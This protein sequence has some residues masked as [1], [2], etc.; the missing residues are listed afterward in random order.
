[1]HTICQSFDWSQ[2][3][4]GASAYW[5]QS[6]RTTVQLIMAS[7][8]PTVVLWGE[9]LIQIYND[10]Y[11]E[12][13]GHR[14]PSGFGQP[15]EQSWPE[16]WD[17]NQSVYKRVW[18]GE[19]LYF[20]DA[21][22][23]IYHLDDSQEA[24]FTLAYS[25]VF[26]DSGHVGGVQLTVMRELTGRV[27]SRIDLVG[28][29]DAL[30]QA[31]KHLR[32]ATEAASMATWEWDLIHNKVYWNEQHF[33]ILGL[34]PRRNPVAP[35]LFF[36]H[37][38]PEDR[39]RVS[40]E[41]QQALTSD[42]L[43]NTEFRVMLE[44]GTVKWMSGYGR[45]ME[46]ADGQPTVMNG[47]MYD[48]TTRREAEDAL[49]ESEE[50]FRAFVTSTSDAVY[51][52][53]ADWQQMHQ[54]VGK[55]FLLDTATENTSWLQSYIPP[56]DQ[57]FVQDAIS[58]AIA[59]KTTF[60]LEHRVILADGELGWTFS[61]AIPKFDNKGDI[62]GWF[63][64][65]SDMTEYK[66]AQEA[67]IESELQYRLLF[68]S[69]D[70]G[71]CTIQLIFDEQ[72]KAVD[73][74]VLQ[75]NPA[76]IRQTGLTDAIGKTMRT[77]APA[78][79]E[80]WFETYGRIAKTGE[81]ARFEHE[82]AALGYFYDV[83]AFRIGPPEQHCVAVL[84]K[85]ISGRKNVEEA[86]RTSE[87]RL[88]A[89]FESLPVGVGE[90]DLQGRIVIANKAMERFMPNGL[91]P[92]LDTASH[93]RWL[94]YNP[95]GS[96]LE[97][98]NYPGAR[99]LRGERVI[100]PIEMRFTDQD[101]TTIWTHVT[102]LPL[103][104]SRGQVRGLIVV[105]TDIND[106]KIAERELQQDDKRKN[107][108]LAMLA[109]ELR[110]PMSTVRNGLSVLSLT[111]PEKDPVMQQT[112]SLMNRQV[113]HL[114]RLIDDLL[115]VSRI[116][117]NKI[118]LRKERTELG[119]LVSDAFKAISGQF[120]AAGKNLLL[121]PLTSKFYV[122]GDATR[123]TQIIIN[124]LTNGLRY[125]GDHG[126]V[127]ISVSKEGEQVL[128]QVT[129]NGIGL[130]EDQLT[131]IFDLF[132]QA[133]NSL[134]RSQGGLGIGLT[135]VQR[136]V[137]MHGGYVEARSP[138]LGQGSE[139]RVYLPLLDESVNKHAPTGNDTGNRPRGQRILV[140]DDNTDATLMV[141]LLLKLKGFQV[142]SR[143]SGLEGIQAADESRPDVI[144]CD[145]GM[146]G[147]DGY[148]T[149]RLIRQHSW[150]K[151]IPLIA[152]TGYGQQEDKQLA[153]DAGF[154]GHLVKP[155]DLRELIQLMDDLVSKS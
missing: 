78:H 104:D 7:P 116:T 128:I 70:E 154:D 137:K 37:I 101:G 74:R 141:T 80:F 28:A 29:E 94:A 122:E 18:K 142:D 105:I 15:I 19:S 129:D 125:T 84:F 145:I 51:Q 55:S 85:D 50:R 114:V 10:G 81:S 95:D 32:L 61:R 124:L 21:F 98:S 49:V 35:E 106:L 46:K 121:A 86:L 108:F 109:H 111:N 143:K 45:V 79:E 66:K 9:A 60:E 39:D 90:L 92:S 4:L 130:T 43:F 65:A 2:T 72:G 31:E 134:A 153:T 132:V 56:E 52:M 13:M 96:R 17:L 47:V 110:N 5:P 148:E 12:L 14:H 126:Q 93:H 63:G 62:I 58:K 59:A 76:F 139:F 135:L 11:R 6:L 118:E 88:A 53:S 57:D 152:L 136:L 36:N 144:L 149:A 131:S 38:H 102:A 138:G 44:D 117:Q 71:F 22:Y 151:G 30:R 77:L 107:E 83:F 40:S 33:K 89:I 112:V 97:E 20:E 27:H 23:P 69:I 119:T 54:L 127:R 146:P 115:D 82:A 25:P 48:I 73:Y 1:M 133:D 41:L 64:T 91:M 147:I 150:G 26:Q 8:F 34:K 113:D 24:R 3:P 100:P 75:A 67:Q 16:I 42:E 103:L 155:V 120:A 68:E 87:A 140:I 123:L 99:A